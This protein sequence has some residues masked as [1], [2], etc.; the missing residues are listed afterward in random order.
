MTEKIIQLEKHQFIPIL[1]C[2]CVHI[3]ICIYTYI[4][5]S[6]V[7]PLYFKFLVCQ[8]YY[9]QY[10]HLSNTNIF[11]MLIKEEIDLQN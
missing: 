3:C 10:L 9:S 1:A 4:Y 7:Y 2:A 5:T 11:V 8:L 6:S